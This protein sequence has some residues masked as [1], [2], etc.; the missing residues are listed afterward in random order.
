M[1]DHSAE[2][3]RCNLGS[4]PEAHAS[5][6]VNDDMLR[7]PGDPPPSPASAILPPARLRSLQALAVPHHRTQVPPS[8]LR[9]PWQAAPPRVFD[10]RNQEGIVFTPVLDDAPDRIPPQRFDL[11]FH[12]RVDDNHHRSRAELLGCRHGRV[13]V[14]DLVQNELVVCSP[15]TR[16]QHRMSVPPEFMVYHLNGTVISA[17]NDEGHVHGGCC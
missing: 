7:P 5:L 16:E 9:T 3:T 13:L 6:P 11:Q 10:R 17:A 1:S 4:S 12:G 2:M 15:I 14:I 8:F